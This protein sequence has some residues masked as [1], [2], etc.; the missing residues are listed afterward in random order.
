[1]AHEAAGNAGLSQQEG[2]WGQR[3]KSQA[4]EVERGGEKWSEERTSEEGGQAEEGRHRG[5]G[6]QE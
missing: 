6:Q 2:L 3:H 1:M 4:M 5:R